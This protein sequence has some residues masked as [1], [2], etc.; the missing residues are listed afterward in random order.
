[1]ERLPSRWLRG[2]L[3]AAAAGL[4]LALATLLLTRDPFH[5]PSESLARALAG[6][7]ALVLLASARGR[8]EILPWVAAAGLGVAAFYNFGS[9]RHWNDGHFVNHWELFHYQLGSKYFPEIG[10]DGLY[11]ASLAAQREV[12][13]DAPLE[14]AIRDLRSNELVPTR[15]VESH[16]R[17]VVDRFDAARWRGFVSDHGFYLAHD[18]PEIIAGMRRD[19]GYNPPPSWTFV[20]RWFS[21]RPSTTGLTLLGLAALDLAL[22]A[23]ALVAIAKTFGF[24]ACCLVL[25]VLGLAH[26]WRYIYV[27]A[28]LRLDWLAA[29]ALGLC[30]L[31]RRRPLLAGVCV[32]YA[33]LS[34][35]FPALLLVGLGLLALRSWWSGERPD[36]PLRL[37]AGFAATVALGLLAGCLAG[38]GVGG[39]S[40]FA[41][42]ISLHRETW[43]PNSV[44]VD[45]VIVNGDTLLGRLAGAELPARWPNPPVQAEKRLEARRPLALLTKGLTLAAVGIAAAVASP[46]RAALLGL[47]LC[48]VAYPLASYYWAMLALWPLAGLRGPAYGVIGLGVLVHVLEMGDPPAALSH[49]LVSVG[50]A[51]LFVWVLLPEVWRAATR[52]S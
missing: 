44:G 10:F 40:E 17:S 18:D 46:T 4:G 49:A 32:G 31:E 43:A 3:T 11:V 8:R 2:A 42:N 16:L 30:L 33:T 27:G 12:A 26:G 5:L 24:R 6:A 29:M 19:H 15:G 37:G 25:A 52:T 51:L 9:F 22:L 38:R 13:P 48:F 39:W 47:P 7:L 36:W 50:L 14:P 41:H 35:L 34:R 45:S 28:F 1:M 20:A 23:V 21:A